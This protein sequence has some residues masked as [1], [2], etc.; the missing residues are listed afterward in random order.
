MVRT[1]EHGFGIEVGEAAQV[2]SF[3]DDAPHTAERCGV[4]LGWVIVGMTL[5]G[6]QWPTN[7]S[8]G[9]VV[10][11]LSK[12]EQGETVVFS[13]EAPGEPNQKLHGA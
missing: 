6:V 7:E 4:E 9:K 1:A 2:L 8:R 3:T 11:L 5:E 12:V 10:E 13:F